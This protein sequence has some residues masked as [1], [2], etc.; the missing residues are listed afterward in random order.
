MTNQLR[1]RINQSE[2][3]LITLDKEELNSDEF[4]GFL[5]RLKEIEK[6]VAK[7]NIETR[8]IKERKKHR[9]KF[10]WNKDKE[11]FL[12]AL[13][14]YYFGPESEKERICSE[15]KSDWSSVTKNII[16][17]KKKFNVQPKEIGL[18]Y[19]P[20]QRGKIRQQS[21]EQAKIRIDEKF[22]K[23]KEGKPKNGKN[24]KI[25]KEYNDTN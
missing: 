6:V 2:V 25:G 22:R 9:E 15:E 16:Y 14:I 13:K 8:P 1:I 19:F 11:K 3:Y 12:K 17:M 21:I 5:E 24:G 4:F 7:G 20:S 23:F 10:S 18:K